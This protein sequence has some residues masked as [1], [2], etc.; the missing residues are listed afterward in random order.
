[1]TPAQIARERTL[2]LRYPAGG[3]WPREGTRLLVVRPRI[4]DQHEQ[5]TAMAVECV[6][7]AH[8]H[9]AR[10]RHPVGG[11][12][13]RRRPS[14]SR[15]ISL[16]IHRFALGGRCRRSAPGRYRLNH[17]SL[18]APISGTLAP[19]PIG[20]GGHAGTAAGRELWQAL[21]YHSSSATVVRFI[22][23]CTDF[24]FQLP[25]PLLRRAKTLIA[26]LDAET[27]CCRAELPVAEP[28][29]LPVL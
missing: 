10:S 3:S 1:M 5:Q 19:R 8:A 27:F 13:C 28:I 22:G 9:R 15:L 18:L 21:G 7:S 2:T 11:C 12:R 23:G 20:R 25:K 24:G 14:A 17:C 29:L 16:P 6:W 4:A 26:D